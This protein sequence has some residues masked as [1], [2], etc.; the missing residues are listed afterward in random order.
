MPLVSIVVL[1]WNGE[2]HVHRC[3]EHVLAQDYRPIE[4]IIVDNNSSDGSLGR[5]KA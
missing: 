5:I 1:N 4:V 2:E 3:L